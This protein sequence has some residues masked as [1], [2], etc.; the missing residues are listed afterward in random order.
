MSTHVAPV[1]AVSR[2]LVLALILLTGA[3]APSAE[4]RLYCGE[5]FTDVDSPSSKANCFEVEDPANPS[6][7]S[8]RDARAGVRRFALNVCVGLPSCYKITVQPSNGCKRVN[9]RTVR[10]TVYYTLNSD[11]RCRQRVEAKA[12]EFFPSVRTV[13]RTTCRDTR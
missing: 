11:S 3:A 12:A 7:I 5:K 8:K 10:C 6:D 2:W 1:C 4:A 13:S 9:R